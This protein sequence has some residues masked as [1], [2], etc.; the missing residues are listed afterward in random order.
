ML[1][2]SFYLY[3]GRLFS[4]ANLK[5]VLNFL[6]KGASKRLGTYTTLFVN[7]PP[8]R[9]VCLA[10]NTDKRST[11]FRSTTSSSSDL[12]KNRLNWLKVFMNGFKYRW[13]YGL[14]KVYHSVYIELRAEQIE[15]YILAVTLIGLANRTY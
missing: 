5:C 10:K 9:L 8:V 11:F 13:E 3:C 7:L 4:I 2:K 6:S 12:F 15:K 1:Y 14:V